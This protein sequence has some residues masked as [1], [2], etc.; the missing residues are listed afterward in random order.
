MSGDLNEARKLISEKTELR[1]TSWRRQ[2]GTLNDCARAGRRRWK[3][4]LFI[5]TF[6]ATSSASTLTSAPLPIR[7]WM[8]RVKCRQQMSPRVT[9]SHSPRRVQN[10]RLTSGKL[11]PVGFD[12]RNLGPLARRWP[13]FCFNHYRQF[14][15]SSE[16]KVSEFA[17]MYWQFLPNCHVYGA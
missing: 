17:L 1:N 11:C 12:A 5:S 15:P 16:L 9:P 13:G 2:S 3:Q 6:C 14:G 7:S 4:P 8:R 10:Q